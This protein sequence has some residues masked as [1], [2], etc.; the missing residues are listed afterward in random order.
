MT[1]F[2]EMVLKYTTF[3]HLPSCIVCEEVM[4]KTSEIYV[5]PFQTYVCRLHH[6]SPLIT[7][8]KALMEE[9]QQHGEQEEEER[10]EELRHVLVQ[11]A[12]QRALDQSQRKLKA[13]MGRRKMDKLAN[14]SKTK[15]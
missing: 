9:Q 10:A 11:F 7:R 12:R 2:R 15:R 13:S 5:Y 8:V 14:Q 6:S 1:L 4:H 3:E